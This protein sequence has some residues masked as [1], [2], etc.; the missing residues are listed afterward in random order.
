MD[1]SCGFLY[2]HALL[3]PRVRLRKQGK[4][5]RAVVASKLSVKNLI[6][7]CPGDF[8]A[9]GAPLVRR[10]AFTISAPRGEKQF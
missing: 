2:P 1:S 6:G 8:Y 7:Q 5:F 3:A 10:H 4:H 9:R